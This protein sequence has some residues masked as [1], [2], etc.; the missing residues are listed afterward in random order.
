VNAPLPRRE[1]VPLRRIAK[2]VGESVLTAGPVLSARRW[3]LRS[4]TLVLAYHNV[5]SD[6]AP[7]EGD[8]SLHLPLGDFAAQLDVLQDGYDVVSLSALAQPHH[9][10]SR[11]RVVITFDDAYRGAVRLGVAELVRRGLPATIFV[12][13]GLLGARTTWWD[14]LAVGDGL[15]PEIRDHALAECEGLEARVLEWA[16]EVGL[17][18]ARAVNAEREIATEQEVLAAARHAGIT[19]GSHTWSHPNLARLD[20]EQIDTELARTDHWLRD[21][22]GAAYEPWLAYPYGLAGEGARAA[23]R[24]LGYRGAFMVVGGWMDETRDDPYAL[25]RLNIPAALSRSGFELRLAGLLTP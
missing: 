22:L 15:P 7:A 24:G 11:P 13:P 8:R 16:A 25:P 6:D 2:R 9:V 1:A 17:P 4:R 12:A 14:A 5:V 3:A 18:C 19:L 21:R 20:V 23:V 10:G